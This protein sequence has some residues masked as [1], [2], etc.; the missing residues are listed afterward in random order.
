MESLKPFEQSLTVL[1]GEVD[2][3]HKAVVNGNQNSESI[4]KVVDLFSKFIF[5]CSQTEISNYKSRL[6]DRSVAVQ[7]SPLTKQQ[8]SQIKEIQTKLTVVLGKK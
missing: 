4:G 6:E 2:R 3:L 8:Q 7:F 1:K 5:A